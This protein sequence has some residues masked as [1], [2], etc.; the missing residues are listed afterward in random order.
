[1]KKLIGRISIKYWEKKSLQAWSFKIETHIVFR[2]K[3]RWKIFGSPIINRRTQSKWIRSRLS[4][5]ILMEGSL[6]DT[7]KILCRISLLFIS[8]RLIPVLQTTPPLRFDQRLKSRIFCPR[9]WGRSWLPR[10]EKFSWRG[11]ASWQVRRGKVSG[12]GSTGRIHAWF[13]PAQDW[14]FC[15][16]RWS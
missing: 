7:L 2:Y 10:A 14:V 16:S 3:E 11:K 5:D 1:M 12:W 13:W 15:L 8:V 6:K 9:F 4:L